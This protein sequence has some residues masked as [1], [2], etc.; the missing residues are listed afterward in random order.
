MPPRSRLHGL[1]RDPD[2]WARV[3]LGLFVLL[4]A[5]TLIYVGLVHP[6]VNP[7]VPGYMP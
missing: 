3:G 5:A 4:T 6:E 7:V 2:F 1:V